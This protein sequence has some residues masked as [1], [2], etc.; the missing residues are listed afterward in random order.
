MTLAGLLHDW[1]GAFVLSSLLAASAL[2]A[3]AA[4]AIGV[5]L[6]APVTGGI[7]A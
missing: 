2:V 6:P 3:A 5:R 7:R 1:T 4:I